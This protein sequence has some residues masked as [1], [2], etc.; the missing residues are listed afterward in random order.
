MKEENVDYDE[1]LNFVNEIGED[2]NI[3]DLEK[4]Y[5]DENEKLEEALLNYIS[6]INLK[7]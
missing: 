7:I 6:E 1:I 2:R 5:P 4:Y 3:E